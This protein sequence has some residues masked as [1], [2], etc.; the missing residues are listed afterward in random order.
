M[1]SECQTRSTTAVIQVKPG[2]GDVIWH[3]PFI[4]AIGAASPGGQVTFLAPPTSNARDLLE[5]E[6]SVAEVLY[7]E[8]GGSELRRGL[9]LL[10]L[11]RLLKQN[12]F[13]TLWVLDRTIRPAL[14]AWL[15]GVPERI[16]LGLGPQR[17]FITNRGIDRKHFHDEPIDWLT[18]LMAAMQVPLPSREPDLPV[19]AETLLDVD[20][21]FA[22]EPRPWIVLGIAASHPDKDWPESH[23]AEFAATL[24]QRTSG[25]V[26]LIGGP[27]LA[28][29][30]QALIAR[31]PR[32]ALINACDLKLM[33]SVAL[34]RHADLFIG[35][36]SGPLNLAAASGTDAFGLFGNTPV[37]TYSRYIHAVVPEGGPS[38]DGMAR[39]TPADVL[40]RIE[41]HL[42]AGKKPSAA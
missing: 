35:P 18:A 11:S 39:I 25:S 33:Q 32:A 38:P 31:T 12:N 26:F 5:E 1:S 4:R 15:G 36:N 20:A 19:A 34:L 24:R 29:R 17:L 27:Q 10:R 8:H 6:P 13:R 23:W 28:A 22:A 2:I 21:K 40:K 14:A 7:F 3:L 16:G 30:A 42:A 37:L 41:P 9:N